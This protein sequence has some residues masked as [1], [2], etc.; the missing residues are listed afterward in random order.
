MGNPVYGTRGLQLLRE[1]RSV[2]ETLDI[3]LADDPERDTRLVGI[4]DARSSA[5]HRCRP[6]AR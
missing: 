5:G 2:K 6:D 4:V 1:G 3:L